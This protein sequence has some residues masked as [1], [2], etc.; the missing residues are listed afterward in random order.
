L[1]ASSLEIIVNHWKPLSIR[2]NQRIEYKFP[3]SQYDV[4][5]EKIKKSFGNPRVL[6]AKQDPSE[7]LSLQWGAYAEKFHV[8]FGKAADG[9]NGWASV[10][11]DTPR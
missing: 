3:L 9:A 4:I 6:I 10:L 11:F 2:A 5:V 7:V 8:S 1:I